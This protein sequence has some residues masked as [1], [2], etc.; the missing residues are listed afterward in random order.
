MWPNG[1][2]VEDVLTNFPGLL[3]LTNSGDL[4][5]ARAAFTNGISRYMAASQFIRNNRPAGVRRLFNLDTNSY[6]EEQDFRTFL[7]DLEGSLSTPFGG[8]G[9]NASVSPNTPFYKCSACSPIIPSPC[10]TSSAAVQS[11]VGAADAD[12]QQFHVYLGHIPRHTLGG[13]ITGLTQT[14]LGQAFLKVFHAQAQLNIPGVTCAVLSSA[15]SNLQ[16]S[17]NG[18][19]LGT[20]GNFYGTTPYGGD[21]GNGAIFKVTPVGGF[22]LLYSFGQVDQSTDGRRQS[23]QSLGRKRWQFLWHHGVRRQVP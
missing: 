22:T 15:P 16:G 19:V 10:R 4:S 6:A 18:V 9:A 23:Q 1:Q 11:A 20:D 2:S 8:P 21:N 5:L 12:H 7:T 13:I 3:T 17:L 14:N